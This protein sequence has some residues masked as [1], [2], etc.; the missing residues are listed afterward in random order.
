MEWPR[1]R[2]RCRRAVAVVVAEVV[3]LP[4]ARRQH[5]GD[6]VLAEVL[7]RDDERRVADASAWPRSAGRSRGRSASCRSSTRDA[8]SGAIRPRSTGAVTGT[9]LHLLVPDGLLPLGADVEDLQPTP[10]RGSS[11][12]GAA[13]WC[14]AGSSR[15]GS[16]PRSP[17]DRSCGGS[18]PSVAAPSM[19]PHGSSMTVS[20]R[21]GAGRRGCR[22]A[23]SSGAGQRGGKSQRATS[24][25]KRLICGVCVLMT[26]RSI[27]PLTGLPRRANGSLT[28]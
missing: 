20:K 12:S 24:C 25:Q 27:R 4:R 6:P 7:R 9:P 5:D 21:R 15:A 8:P 13:L 19:S 18:S 17:A 28:R 14:R 3:G 2:T 11:R 26:P 23:R 22:A 16:T 1:W 10:R